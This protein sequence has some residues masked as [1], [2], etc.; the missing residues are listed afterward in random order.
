MKELK[1]YTDGACRGNPGPGAW[2]GVILHESGHERVFGFEKNTTN[3]RME[4]SAVIFTLKKIDKDIHVILHTD[5]QYVMKGM[6]EWVKNW[7]K[8]GWRTSNNKPVKNM[9]LWQIL[10]EVCDQRNIQWKWVKGHSGDQYNE[11][12]DTI[13]NEAI[14]QNVGV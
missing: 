11:L 1:V 2:A 8:R 5:S 9:D 3:N 10:V 12:A 13:A 14:D 7:Q 4:L 6:M